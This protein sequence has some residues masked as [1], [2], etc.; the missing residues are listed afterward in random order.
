M[1]DKEVQMTKYQVVNVVL[2]MKMRSM[3]K[4]A[5]MAAG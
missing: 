2:L 4:P 1:Y 5:S 3:R